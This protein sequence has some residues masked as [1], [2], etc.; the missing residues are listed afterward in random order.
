MTQKYTLPQV[1]N[2]A[3]FPEVVFVPPAEFKFVRASLK[4]P[5]KHVTIAGPSGTGKTTLIR[6]LLRDLDIGETDFHW[7]NGRQYAGIESGLAVLAQSLGCAVDFEEITELLNTVKHVIIDDFHFLHSAARKEIAA[8]LKLWHEKNVRFVIVGIASSADEL[9]QVDPELGI[10]NDPYSFKQQSPKFIEE[11]LTLGANALNI[12]FSGA[13]TAEIVQACNG[14]PSIAHVIARI[15]C[16]STD[17][18]ETQDDLTVLELNLR[19]LRTEVLRIF[20]GKYRDKVV[21]LA[22]GKRQARAVH[23]TYFDIVYYIIKSELSEIPQENLYHAIVGNIG[24]AKERA[25]KAT[26]FYNCMN[27]LSEVIEQQG[28]SDTM[29]YNKG[30]KSVSIEDPSFR[31]YLSLL[32]TDEIKARIHVRNSE[33]PYDVAVSF[34]GDVRATVEQFVSALKARGLNVFYDFDQQAQLWG[35]DLRVKLS[36]VY[37]EEALYMVVF[38]SDSYPTRD[39][40][41]LELQVGKAAAAKRTDEYLLPLR[42]DDVNVVGIKSTIGHLD[43]NDIGIDQAA[44]ILAEKVSQH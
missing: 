4:T 16:V 5:G 42:L 20:H 8:N 26:S 18:E 21:A 32:D 35:T 9:L 28:L 27:N 36:E 41:D 1:F 12:S 3:A 22:K 30:S 24:D 11:L 6:R 37:A 38:L 39:W 43:L 13:L 44:D 7:M 31:F 29:L 19:D 25:R 14:V 15:C 33:Y 34:A 23:N 10:R 17:I 2:E 40:T